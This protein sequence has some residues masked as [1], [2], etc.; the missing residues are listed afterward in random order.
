M[1]Q[2]KRSKEI[3]IQQKEGRKERKKERKK[4]KREREK[5]RNTTDGHINHYKIHKQNIK[6]ILVQQHEWGK[7]DERLDEGSTSLLSSSSTSSS[8]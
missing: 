8:L 4:R 3:L 2:Q 6:K 5:E 7:K 1:N